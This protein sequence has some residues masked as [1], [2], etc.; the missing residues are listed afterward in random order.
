MQK[1]KEK[2]SFVPFCEEEA[3]CLLLTL[4]Q[5]LL[6]KTQCGVICLY[7]CCCRLMSPGCGGFGGLGM[8]LVGVPGA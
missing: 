6:G 5:P 3:L 4:P 7:F 1:L 8:G 2:R